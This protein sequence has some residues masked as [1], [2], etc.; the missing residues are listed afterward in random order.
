[1]LTSLYFTATLRF[2]FTKDGIFTLYTS[3]HYT[4]EYD[5]EF[6]T[7]RETIYRGVKIKRC[8]KKSGDLTIPSKIL[9]KR[10]IGIEGSFSSSDEITSVVISEDGAMY[11]GDNAFNSCSQLTSVTIPTCVHSIG[12]FAF[13][14]CSSL[15]TIEYQ[16]TIAEWHEIAKGIAWD[17]HTG[18]YTIHCTDGNIQKNAD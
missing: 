6:H 2:A 8:S 5:E 12:S 14:H 7:N 17:S 1:M 4:Y 9:G 18:N 13:Y 16:G 11:V 3:S 15:E 10:V